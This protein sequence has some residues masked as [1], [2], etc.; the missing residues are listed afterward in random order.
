MMV[1]ALQKIADGFIL[2][3]PLAKEHP[4]MDQSHL[5]EVVTV[6]DAGTVSQFMHN[7]LDPR[8]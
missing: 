1:A 2:R 8:H 6:H 7:A 5:R 3:G 4:E